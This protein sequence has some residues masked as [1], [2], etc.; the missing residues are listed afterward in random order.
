MKSTFKKT[1]WIFLIEGK[2]LTSSSTDL[3]QGVLDAPY[4]SL[5][6]QTKFTNK[7]RLLVQALFFEGTTWRRV[8]L[9]PNKGYA[10]HLESFT[11]NTTHVRYNGGV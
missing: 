11:E 4:L 8:G 1:S 7:L 2:Q 3:G 5:V 6:A 10:W 9:T